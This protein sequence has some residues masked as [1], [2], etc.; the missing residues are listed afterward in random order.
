LILLDKSEAVRRSDTFDCFKSRGTI[1]AD[2][3][4]F[5]LCGNEF[6]TS[7][8]FHNIPQEALAT[9]FTIGKNIETCFFLVPHGN[10]DRILNR[11][12]HVGG[13]CVPSAK[14]PAHRGE[15]CWRSVR[16]N[17]H[18]RQE[19]EVNSVEDWHF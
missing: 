9:Y 6:Q 1:V 15:P 5:T 17:S 12:F 10:L 8:F 11:F 16:P 4:K 3:A 18:S 14:Y 19:S 2:N 7:K 13:T